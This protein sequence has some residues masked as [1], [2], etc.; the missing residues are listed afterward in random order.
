MTISKKFLFLAC[1]VA[2]MSPLAARATGITA[3][4][5]VNLKLTSSNGQYYPYDFTIKN[6]SSTSYDVAMS[7]LNDD[8]TV[9]VNESWSATA[10]GLE[11]LISNAPHSGEVDGSSITG[12]EED[13]YLDSLYITNSS[14][15]NYTVNNMEV[16]D[17]IWSVLSNPT[18]SGL[19]TQAEKDAEAADLSAAVASLSYETSAFYSQFTFYYPSTDNGNKWGNEPQQFMGYCPTVTPEPSSLLLLGTGMAGLAW[20]VRRRMLAARV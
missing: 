3:P 9:D 17:A 4:V 1:I 10:E 8:R 12:L 14:N 2:L 11:Y 19:T 13:A 6:G 7:C 16:Q 15:P 5:A 18:H 20:I